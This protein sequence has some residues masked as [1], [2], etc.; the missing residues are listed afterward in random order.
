MAEPTIEKRVSILEEMVE[1]VPR[2][3][4]LRF[5]FLRS[6][7]EAVDARVGTVEAKV[8]RLHAEVQALPRVLA[9]MLDERDRRKGGQH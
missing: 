8:D 3:V 6:Q 1:D 5:S 4:N 2:L 9:E 7:I